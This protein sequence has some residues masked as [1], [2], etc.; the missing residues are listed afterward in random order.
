MNTAI[1]EP[2]ASGTFVLSSYCFASARDWARF[3]MLYLN[4]G[5]WNG[6]R[7]LPEGWVQYSTT[8]APAATQ[9]QY[10]AQIWLN[11]GSAGD[12][13]ATEFPGLPNETILFE[14]FERNFV[15]II[16]SRKLVVVRLGVTHNNNFSMANLVNEIIQSLPK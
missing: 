7:I 12:S 11:R 16:P 13:L 8:P 6:E 9:G 15:A 5:V 2:D 1:L 4:D 3:G 14:G 10:G